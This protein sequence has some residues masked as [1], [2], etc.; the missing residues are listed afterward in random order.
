MKV[1]DIIKPENYKVKVE[2]S[3][4]KVL[5]LMT[6][7]HINGIPVVDDLDNLVGMVVKADIYRFMIAPG[8]YNSCPVE[9]VMSK[10]VILADGDEDIL[11]V[12]KRLRNN[13]INSM[14]I[15]S[16]NKIIGT[17]STEDL[18]DYYIKN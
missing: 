4:D 11:T 8:H 7:L 14:P 18:L 1:R 16:D 9:W 3:I 12:A 15:I 6:K 2:D 17:V 10:S 13:D 5:E